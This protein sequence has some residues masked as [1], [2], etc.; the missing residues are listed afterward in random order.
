MDA[1]YR[2]SRAATGYRGLGEFSVQKPDAIVLDLGLPDIAGTE[3]VR[4]VRE[5]SSVPII[6]ITIG[7][8]P[9]EDAA[10]RDAGA[11]EVIVRPFEVGELLSRLGRLVRDPLR[12]DRQP[13]AS[14]FEVGDLHVDLAIRRVTLGKKEV[15]LSP[16]EFTLL[17]TLI[18]HAGRVVTYRFLINQLWNSHAI[19][20]VAYL[21]LLVSS[22]RHKLEPDPVRP[23]YVPTERGTGYRLAAT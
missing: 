14:H 23:R 12:I 3:V 5:R 19:W 16:T 21:K 18:N 11:N 13:A 20:Q 8:Q 22:L 4:Q 9:G 7:S 2:V 15:H 17:A 6:A 1:G 10:A